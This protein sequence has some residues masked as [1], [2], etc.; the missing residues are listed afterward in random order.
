MSS[1]FSMR[2]WQPSQIDDRAPRGKRAP[3]SQQVMM[4]R[5][6]ASRFGQGSP[7]VCPQQG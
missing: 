6:F 4:I 5:P 2:R 1:L 7:D 3:H